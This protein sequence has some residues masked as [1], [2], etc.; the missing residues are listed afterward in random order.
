MATVTHTATRCAP[1]FYGNPLLIGNT[2]RKC[3][4]SGNSDPNLIFEDCDEATGQYCNKC[5]WDLTGDL[6]LAALSIGESVSGLLSVSS[7][8]AAQRHVNEMNATIHLLKTKLS[9]RENQYILRKIQI[10]NSEN[11][12]KSLLSDVEELAEKILEPFPIAC[13]WEPLKDAHASAF[14]T[15]GAQRVSSRCFCYCC[16]C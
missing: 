4:C 9:E 3:D 13:F 1:G 16:C 12:M 8:T 15:A 6:R 7:G 5:V 10:S 2:C 14:I 11:T